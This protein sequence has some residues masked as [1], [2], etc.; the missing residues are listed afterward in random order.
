MGPTVQVRSWSK[1]VA[2]Q[3]VAAESASDRSPTFMPKR[4]TWPRWKP[5]LQSRVPRKRE[6][7]LKPQQKQ[8]LCWNP[9][10]LSTA[11]FQNQVQVHQ[12]CGVCEQ[13]PGS[14]EDIE[15]DAS[16]DTIT[17]FLYCFFS[18]TSCLYISYCGQD[19][20]KLAWGVKIGPD[21]GKKLQLPGFRSR[22]DQW[23]SD[24]I[25]VLNKCND[26]FQ[27]VRPTGE[28]VNLGNRCGG[29]EQHLFLTF[30]IEVL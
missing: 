9:A 2:M 11:C 17:V 13:L 23:D 22:I 21:G 1:G 6:R 20:F 28:P 26:C 15:A 18:L 12:Q 3:A 19:K 24:F 14:V 8:K 10:K 30:V 29:Q 25:I 16:A 5:Q 7:Q 27:H 4:H